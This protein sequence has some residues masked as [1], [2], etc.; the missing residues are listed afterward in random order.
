M[1]ILSRKLDEKIVIGN[2]IEVSIL[3]IRG[4]QVKLGVNAPRAVKVFRSEVFDAI[5]AENRAAAASAVDIPSIGL[6]RPPA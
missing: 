6:P 3:E 4:D 2:D 5:Q 1:L